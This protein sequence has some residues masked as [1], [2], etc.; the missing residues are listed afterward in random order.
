MI[1][2]IGVDPHV[3]RAR[4]VGFGMAFLDGLPEDL[5]VG[6]LGPTLP[7][8]ELE[9]HDRGPVR[10]QAGRRDARCSYRFAWIEHG[11]VPTGFIRAPAKR[12]LAEVRTTFGPGPA[13]RE[14]LHSGNAVSPPDGSG[15][16]AVLFPVRAGRRGGR[17]RHP[18]RLK[19]ELAVIQRLSRQYRTVA[20]YTSFDRTYRPGER[21]AERF[22]Y[23]VFG[24][25]L[26]AYSARPTWACTRTA[27]RCR[28]R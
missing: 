13:D 26:P 25:G 14:Y 3:R 15:G 8:D 19:L 9:R 16:W 4:R 24:P 17:L 27:S 23:P 5:T 12:E 20:D 18:D 28:C 1:G 22:S 10:G 6:Q 2:D 11:R 7:A 21:D